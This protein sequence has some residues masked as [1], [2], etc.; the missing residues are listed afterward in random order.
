MR[1][2]SKDKPISM[3]YRPPLRMQPV[4]P[5]AFERRASPTGMAAGLH[6]R[7]FSSEPEPKRGKFFDFLK[8]VKRTDEKVQEKEVK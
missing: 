3:E 4:R 8:A 2:L 1:A 7:P 5:K 6:I